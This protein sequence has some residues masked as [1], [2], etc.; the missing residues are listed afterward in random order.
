[1]SYYCFFS[2]DFADFK[3]SSSDHSL[4]PIQVTDFPVNDTAASSMSPVLSN[5]AEPIQP[6]SSTWVVPPIPGTIPKPDAFTDFKSAPSTMDDDFADFKS[7]KVDEEKGDNILDKI[8]S[9]KA[10]VSNS[11]LFSATPVVVDDS[12]VNMEDDES[13]ND[14]VTEGVGDSIPHTEASVQPPVFTASFDK[15]DEEDDWANF[16]SAA[17]AAPPSTIEW[18]ST[19]TNVKPK[20]TDS[21]INVPPKDIPVI[22]VPQATTQYKKPASTTSK[23]NVH[24]YFSRNLAPKGPVAGTGMSPLD[25]QPPDLPDDDDDDEFDEFG[26][27]HSNDL[28]EGGGNRDGISSLTTP[29]GGLDDFNDFPVPACPSIITSDSF[30]SQSQLK[31]SASKDT[32]DTQSNSSLEFTGWRSQNKQVIEDTQSTNSLELKQSEMASKE[33]TPGGVD[34]QSVSSLEIGSGD[35]CNGH[36]VTTSQDSRSVASLEFK[37]NMMDGSSNVTTPLENGQHDKREDF[38][39]FSM[40]EEIPHCK[41]SSKKRF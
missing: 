21:D 15:Q 19:I 13:T 3:S 24:N 29:Y 8:S 37:S 12:A 23:D 41:H 38:G 6:V 11:S 4:P 28:F 17:P 25:L 9:L 39:E 10:L 31:T 2:D 35:G 1:M 5:K 27:F 22:D 30:G 34:S 18:S 16:S 32:F 20:S 14:T 7:A 40:A 26:T 33:S 36:K